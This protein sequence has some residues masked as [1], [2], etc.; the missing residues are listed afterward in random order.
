MAEALRSD[1]VVAV[2]ADTKRAIFGASPQRFE[3]QG[4][5]F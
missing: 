2:R 5:G 4:T 1:F 3:L